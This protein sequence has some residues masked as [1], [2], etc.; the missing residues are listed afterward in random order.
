MPYF[1]EFF[2]LTLVHLLAVMSPG[3][4]FAIVLRQSISFGRKTAVITSLGIGAGIAVHVFYT[5][6]GMGLLISQSTYLMLSAKVIGAIYISYLGINLLR[7]PAGTKESNPIE[8]DM[9]KKHQTKAFMI[10]FMTNVFNPKVTLFF[11]A[12]FTT[13]VSANTPIVIQ[14][15]YG[16][17]I[18]LTTAAWFSL[19]SFLFSKPVIRAKFLRHGYW[20][21]RAMG[22]I[23]I[24]FAIKL[25][26][27]LAY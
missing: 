26:L 9:N 7:S 14:S 10:G 15:F 22:G 19:V 6:L 12:I 3:P 5:L 2:M 17:W 27:E 20:F 11:L 8:T 16:L 21:E 24:A 23:L 4:D 18:V 1:Q 13:I 25:F